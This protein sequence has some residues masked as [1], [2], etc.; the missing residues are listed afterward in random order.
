MWDIIIVGHAL[1][2]Q[3]QTPKAQRG[4]NYHKSQQLGPF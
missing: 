1:R 3:F 4:E 2:N